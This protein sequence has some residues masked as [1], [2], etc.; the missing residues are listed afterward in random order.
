MHVS[1]IISGT[2]QAKTATTRLRTSRYCNT[3]QQPATRCL[4]V[5]ADV[6]WSALQCTRVRA[7]VALLVTLACGFKSACWSVL[8]LLQRQGTSSRHTAPRVNKLQ[9]SAT[10]CNALQVAWDKGATAQWAWN[11][12]AMPSLNWYSFSCC[13][14]ERVALCGMLCAARCCTVLQCAAGLCS[15]GSVGVCRCT[16]LQCL[17]AYC[18]VLQCGAVI[19]WSPTRL[20]QRRLCAFGQV[21]LDAHHMSLCK[22]A[23][24]HS[25]QEA[26]DTA[27]ARS[28][29]VK[30]KSVL[31]GAQE[32]VLGCNKMLLHWHATACLGMQQHLVAMQEHLVAMQQL[33]CLALESL[34]LPLTSLA[35]DLCTSHSTIYIYIYICI[36]IYMPRAILRLEIGR[37]T[38]TE[39]ETD[40]TRVASYAGVWHMG[41]YG[42]WV[43][44]SARLWVP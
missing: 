26:L 36:Y 8:Q 37:E 17:A 35:L 16:L 15:R 3:L 28:R 25:H 34:V 43:G 5:S 14:V 33:P 21:L 29:R 12:N 20:A 32:D 19:A 24:T 38:E 31:A 6:H 30:K 22:D 2:A 10:H 13:L 27:A 41:C 40:E 9:H 11:N 18:S 42:I 39:I 7:S 44:Y 4:C 23:K 1:S